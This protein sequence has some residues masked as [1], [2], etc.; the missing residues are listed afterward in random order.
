[1]H[2]WQAELT[3]SSTRA[4]MPRIWV[5]IILIITV[6]IIIICIT[7]KGASPASSD[8]TTADHGVLSSDDLS[9]NLTTIQSFHN[10]SH[11]EKSSTP[12]LPR[13]RQR[14]Q[15]DISGRMHAPTTVYSKSNS[16][17]ITTK[18]SSQSIWDQGKNYAS[19]LNQSH[20][21]S[22]VE[23]A[24]RIPHP[25]WTVVA[26]ELIPATLETA[27]SSDLPGMVR[28]VTQRPVYAFQGRRILI[29]AG[30][31][32]LGQYSSMTLQG[33]N[34]VCVIWHRL[35]L[36]SGITMSIDSPST[37]TLGQAG[38]L[39]DHMNTH[40]RSRFEQGIL[41][42]AL[43]AGVSTVGVS[44]SDGNNSAS[45]FRANVSDHLQD[46][47]QASLSANSSIKPTL[48]VYQGS[49]IQIFVAKDLSFYSVRDHS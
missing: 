33:I 36:P 14:L 43:G 20:V 29:P 6:I 8:H 45:T 13:D 12:V 2:D 31:R 22:S 9:R 41:I 35:I 5:A 11:S 46:A 30:S 1:M 44:S 49:A 15:R 37:D 48:S 17:G 32:V 34:R 16:S 10:V 4:R 39:A 24:Q 25:D 21:F 42:S 40:F 19:F 28:A 3:V 23:S 26:G 38:Q 27:I 7:G 47:A 18:V